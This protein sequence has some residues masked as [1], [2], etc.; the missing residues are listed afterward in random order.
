MQ[1]TLICGTTVGLLM[2]AGA[3][4]GQSKTPALLE[5]TSKGKAVQGKLAAKD[6]RSCWLLGRDGYLSELE[7]RNVEEYRIAAPQFQR[8]SPA[9]L[10]D[11]LR[12][13]FGGNLEIAGTEHYLVCAAPGKAGAYAA[14]FE[15][16][17]RGFYSYASTRGFRVAK[18]EFP[19]VAVVLP[20]RVAFA[21]YCK[22][23]GLR[24]TPG[25]M[26][27]YHRLT[28]RVAL[29]DAGDEKVSAHEMPGKRELAVAAP[30]GNLPRSSVFA[31]IEGSLEDTI[32]HETTHQVAFNLGLHTRI[33]ENPQ[34]VVEGLATVFEAPGIR[35]SAS[36]TSVETRLNRER[37]LWFGE[38]R[39][40]RRKPK[41]LAAFVG[42][43]ALFKSATLDAY[44][45][46]WALSFYLIE[47]RPSQYA[48]YLKGISER[49]PLQPY[50]PTER[51]D[52][53]KKA[54]GADLAL[55]EADFLRFYERLK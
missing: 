49:N 27:Y 44:S 13:E 38:Y 48:R 51:V 25:L 18:P 6:D 15:S 21:D 11:Q 37:Y 55:L 43:D 28:N 45:E 53:F 40:S 9:E 26:G 8:F 33:G 7:L 34:W 22:K 17:Y 47:S 41:S 31:R 23:D 4:C 29:F 46:A 3:A 52:D 10:R 2:M 14:V 5:L 24:A 30:F 50:E 12:R 16:V 42:S 19:L 32:I 35:N 54:F 36:N 1:R 39:K 20:G